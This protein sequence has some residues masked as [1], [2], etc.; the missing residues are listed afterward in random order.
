MKIKR[1]HT[2]LYLLIIVAIVVLVITLLPRG[3]KVKTLEAYE[4]IA[5]V[6]NGE[7]EKVEIKD[8][9]KLSI[10]TT[11]GDEFKSTL[12]TE[13]VDDFIALLLEYNVAFDT[14]Y[15]SGFDWTSLI[16]TLL[17]VLLLVGLFWFLL[18]G[19]RGGNSQAF[20]FSRS[21]A[22][23]FSGA[24]PSVTFADVAGIEEAKQELEEIVEFLKSPE[25]FTALGAR[26]PRGVLLIGPPGTG[27]TLLARAIAGEAAVPFFSISGSEF[28]EMFVGGGAS[29]VRAL[30][31]QD[32]RATPC[33]IFV[34]EIDAVGRHRGAGMGGGDDEREK[35]LNQILVEMDG[36]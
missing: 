27:K 20:N 24:K 9:R 13:Y 7:V 6:E 31:D 30:F 36:L 5:M 21:R 35:T 33:L 10:T 22:R 19:A 23:L 17:P 12:S 11:A 28:V 14:P 34:D 15:S 8:D 16:F 29:R 18:R 26:I 32:T 2:L 25:K 3:E 1:Q 4:V